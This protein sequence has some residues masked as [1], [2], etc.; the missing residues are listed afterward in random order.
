MIFIYFDSSFF[1][2]FRRFLVMGVVV[3]FEKFCFFIFR[4]FYSL[5][6]M[7]RE[8]REGGWNEI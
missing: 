7:R 6:I 3:I 5:E 1:G 8:F 2:V 4:C